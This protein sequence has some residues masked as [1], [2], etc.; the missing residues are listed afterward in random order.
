MKGFNMTNKETIEILDKL[1]ENVSSNDGEG[2]K[3]MI[4]PYKPCDVIVALNRSADL[5]RKEIYENNITEC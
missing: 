1:I 2:I 5:F 4:K 3:E